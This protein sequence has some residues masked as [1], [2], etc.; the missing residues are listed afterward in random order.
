M[1]RAPQSPPDAGERETKAERDPPDSI[2]KRG[3][4]SL[5]KI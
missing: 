1:L 5:P 3:T 4:S 2:E